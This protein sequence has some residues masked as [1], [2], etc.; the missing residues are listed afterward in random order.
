MQFKLVS[1]NNAHREQSQEEIIYSPVAKRVQLSRFKARIA[2]F[3]GGSIFDVLHYEL[4]WDSRNP[5]VSQ[6]KPSFSMPRVTQHSCGCV[7]VWKL[8]VHWK[9][10]V[11]PVRNGFHGQEKHASEGR[12]R[13][14]RLASSRPLSA[15]LSRLVLLRIPP[16]PSPTADAGSQLVPLQIQQPL[17]PPPTQHPVSPRLVRSLSPCL[18]SSSSR[19]SCRLHLVG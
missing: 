8:E 1:Q 9:G 12:A 17:H 4:V 14:H 18:T 6:P 3:C 16:P 10:S 15:S 5:R 7:D 19:S 2:L 13:N 11:T